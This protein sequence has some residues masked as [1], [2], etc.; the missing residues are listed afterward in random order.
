[1]RSE[2]RRCVGVRATICVFLI[3]LM[4]SVTSFGATQGRILIDAY[5]YGDWPIEDDTADFVTE[6][7]GFGFEVAYHT[8]PIT[9]EVLQQ[10]D[11]FAELFPVDEVPITDAEATALRTWVEQGHGLWLGSGINNSLGVA[12]ELNRITDPWNVHFNA[13]AYT[14]LVTDIVEHPLTDGV[15][16]VAVEGSCSVDGVAPVLRAFNGVTLMGVLEPGLGRVAL[17]GDSLSDGVLQTG[18]IYR[19]D[20][21]GLALNTAQ[22]LVP[23]PATVALLGMGGLSLVRMRRRRT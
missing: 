6:L 9:P 7:R 4:S 23:E 10:C 8:G 11:V 15:S 5:H 19:A 14:S 17:F 3:A 21:L 20:N 22:W 12:D 13:D 1:M 16:A 18:T 2:V